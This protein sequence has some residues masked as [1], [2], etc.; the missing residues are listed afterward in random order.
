MECAKPVFGVLEVIRDVDV[1]LLLFSNLVVLIGIVLGVLGVC[2]VVRGIWVLVVGVL[3]FVG[4]CLCCR[5]GCC[6]CLVLGCCWCS[7][8]GLLG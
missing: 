5:L 4:G 6:I 2:D 8:G 3:L 7:C 1:V